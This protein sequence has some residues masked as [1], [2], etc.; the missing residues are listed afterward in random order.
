MVPGI[1]PG[2]HLQLRWSDVT[3]KDL[4]DLNIRKE[5]AE[6]RVEWQRATMPR[7]IQLQGVR[8]IRG[9]KTL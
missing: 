4:K 9:G 1:L 2:G 5:L 7:K 8:T 6:E 3:T